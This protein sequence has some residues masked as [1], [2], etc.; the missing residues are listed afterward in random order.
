M[1]GMGPTCTG[2]PRVINHEA[3]ALPGQFLGDYGEVFVLNALQ[4]VGQPGL[5]YAYGS[6]GLSLAAPLTTV[7]NWATFR[8]SAIYFA[9]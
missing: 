7:N 9:S 3:M 8:T 5:R 1:G 4:V 2:C 6:Y